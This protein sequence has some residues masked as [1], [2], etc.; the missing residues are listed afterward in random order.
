[1]NLHTYFYNNH[2][3]AKIVFI[4]TRYNKTQKSW[5]TKVMSLMLMLAENNNCQTTEAIVVQWY[6]RSPK[7]VKATPPA[8]H[9]LQDQPHACGQS[10]RVGE[11]CSGHPQCAHPEPGYSAR[12]AIWAWAGTRPLSWGRASLSEWMTYP[13]SAGPLERGDHLVSSPTPPHPKSLKWNKSVMKDWTNKLALC[14]LSNAG[15]RSRGRLLAA[16]WSQWGSKANTFI[17]EHGVLL[18]SI[19]LRKWDFGYHSKKVTFLVQYVE[20]VFI[21]ISMHNNDM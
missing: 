5:Y 13:L 11:R 1:M 9:L 2:Q 21:H 18:R 14:K 3:I 19:H 4:L 17:K 12:E 16:T 8:P 7:I 6:N 15:A 20:V 10:L